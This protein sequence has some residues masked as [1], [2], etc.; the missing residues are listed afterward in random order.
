MLAE[1]PS[2]DFLQTLARQAKYILDRSSLRKRSLRPT[3]RRYTRAEIAAMEKE[4][5]NILDISKYG[6][7]ASLALKMID[8]AVSV[9]NEWVEL[10]PVFDMVDKCLKTENCYLEVTQEGYFLRASNGDLL[11]GGAT[12]RSWLT[13]HAQL[14]GD[15]VTEHYDRGVE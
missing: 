7:C 6:A 9:D 4:A 1:Q 8:I 2:P 12:L 15:R 10:F 11:S 3:K 13:T 5:H 14:Y